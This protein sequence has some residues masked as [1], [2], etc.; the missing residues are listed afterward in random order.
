MAENVLVEVRTPAV[1]SSRMV[2][3]REHVD[4]ARVILL[5]SQQSRRKL[6]RVVF[7]IHDKVLVARCQTFPVFR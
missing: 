1:P 6:L 2:A 5:Q 4:R 7:R 3:S